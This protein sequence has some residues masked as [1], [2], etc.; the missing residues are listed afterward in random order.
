MANADPIEAAVAPDWQI[1]KRAAAQLANLEEP[2]ALAALERLLHDSD[3]A[4]IDAATEA[5]VEGRGIDGLQI[6]LQNL[7]NPDDEL[8]DNLLGLLRAYSGSG[9]FPIVSWLQELT[10]SPDTDTRRRARETLEWFGAKPG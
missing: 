5:L 6:A 8:G 9:R 3:T 2:A 1:R 7:D 4:V 10:E